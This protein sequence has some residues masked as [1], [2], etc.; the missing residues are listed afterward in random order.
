[1]SAYDLEAEMALAA[2]YRDEKF[3]NP[4]KG[5]AKTQEG[6]EKPKHRK[7]LSGPLKLTSPRGVTAHLAGV[8]EA[9]DGSLYAKLR[10]GPGT[11]EVPCHW[12]PPPTLRGSGSKD[13][14]LA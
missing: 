12:G 11:I 4:W 5:T 10:I 2:R 6:E 13:R 3:K 1:M 8:W 7:I 9:E 14:K